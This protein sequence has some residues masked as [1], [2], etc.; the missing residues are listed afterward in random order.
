MVSVDV[1]HHVYLQFRKYLELVT[2]I[3]AL[4]II[5]PN[6]SWKTFNGSNSE[7]H[8]ASSSISS[9]MFLEDF[10]SM[11]SDTT[12]DV[13]QD[14]NTDH[15]DNSNEV[16]NKAFEELKILSALQNLKSNKSCCRDQII[17]DFLKAS[18]GI[19]T[20]ATKLFD[21]IIFSGKTPNESSIGMIK[22]II[23]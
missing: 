10:K 20:E 11:F 7:K 21:S 1:K 15:C 9:Q 19:M 8:D 3:R 22:P 23:I 16:L 2:K 12:R 13:R 18:A 17:D 14:P 6:T 4:K 5:Y